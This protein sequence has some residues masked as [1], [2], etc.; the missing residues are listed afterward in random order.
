MSLSSSSVHFNLN[1]SSEFN[2]QAAL[3]DS[4]P[5]AYNGDQEALRMLQSDY[6]YISTNLNEEDLVGMER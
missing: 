4:P 6:R 5:Q 2:L 1:N 3:Q